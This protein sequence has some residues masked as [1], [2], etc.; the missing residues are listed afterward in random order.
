MDS[1]PGGRKRP[2]VPDERATTNIPQLPKRG[3]FAG[4]SASETESATPFI[5][6]KQPQRRL[7]S[8]LSGRKASR[9]AVAEVFNKTSLLPDYGN[10]CFINTSLHFLSHAFPDEIPRELWLCAIT[11][12]PGQ[13]VAIA[14]INLLAQ[15]KR[16]QQGVPVSDVTT[17]QHHLNFLDACRAYAAGATP[18]LL[19]LEEEFPFQPSDQELLKA[20]QEGVKNFHLHQRQ[21]RH[22]FEST[23]RHRRP[24]TLFYIRQQDPHEFILQILAITGVESTG[25]FQIQQRDVLHTE[26]SGQHR[27]KNTPRVTMPFLSLPVAECDDFQQSLAHHLQEQES[28]LPVD[29]QIEDDDGIEQNYSLP[30]SRRTEYST[31]PA[32]SGI[33]LQ[34]DCY[35]G[36]DGRAEYLKRQARTMVLASSGVTSLP[37]GEDSAESG[38]QI[39]TIIC[40]KGPELS[41]GHYT[42]VR[43]QDDRWVFIDDLNQKAFYTQTLPEALNKAGTPYLVHCTLTEIPVPIETG[44][45][46]TVIEP[47]LQPEPTRPTA[48]SKLMEVLQKFAGNPVFRVQG[49]MNDKKGKA[50]AKYPIPD[51]P[52]L[53]RGVKGWNNHLARYVCQ[54]KGIDLSLRP[55]KQSHE[56]HCGLCVLDEQSPQ[57]AA[58]FKQFS[59]ECF[60]DI[61]SLP[62]LCRRLNFFK[63]A[64]PNW[65]D[66]PKGR[67][68]LHEWDLKCTEAALSYIGLTVENALEPDPLVN[69]IVQAIRKKQNVA[70]LDRRYRRE[71]PGSG[72]SIHPGYEPRSF[73]DANP[74][75]TKAWSLTMVRYLTH[76]HKDLI[77]QKLGHELPDDWKITTQDK[78]NAFK[79]SHPEY[80][81]WVIDRV[82][83]LSDLTLHQIAN[84]LS[85]HGVIIPDTPNNTDCAGTSNWTSPRLV[86]F[87]DDTN[88]FLQHRTS[89]YNEMLSTMKQDRV[90]NICTRLNSLMEG[91]PDFAPPQIAGI[92]PELTH[93]TAPL[94]R[95]VFEREKIAPLSEQHEELWISHLDYLKVFAPETD[96]YVYSMQQ[97]LFS[98]IREEKLGFHEVLRRLNRVEHRGRDFYFQVPGHPQLDSAI[99]LWQKAPW[100][101]DDLR[102]VLNVYGLTAD[103]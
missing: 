50:K 41:Y 22:L 103:S 87:A 29:W 9:P 76:I 86:N 35:V 89:G 7:N 8:Y 2:S 81:N 51:L 13:A 90:G 48:D 62:H 57:Y 99:H 59:E 84:F 91:N 42:I 45:R 58:A 24:D 64:V 46:L 12:Q 54:Q 94:A 55:L 21:L 15:M 17:E 20:T 23:I 6:L 75:V 53:H 40:H 31:P 69:E 92:R 28:E 47:V 27:Y 74:N 70:V 36:R 19:E 96:E 16:Y 78:L 11:E 71:T 4:T 60:Q 37:I 83:E 38:V 14:L 25:G 32:A 33:L 85:S 39:N 1:I 79:P 67:A 61:P 30:T 101:E 73:P 93:W 97:T 43:K 56:G 102:A 65:P 82:I 3:H 68:G 88:I 100:T 5:E 98:W 80:K 10:N 52:G 44:E 95:V 49:S 18:E 77:E 66:M 34:L 63:V 26:F 72:P